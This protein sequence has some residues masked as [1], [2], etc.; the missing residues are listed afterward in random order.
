MVGLLAWIVVFLA[1]FTVLVRVFV[2]GF[3]LGLMLWLRL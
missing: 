3:R 2:L 1:W